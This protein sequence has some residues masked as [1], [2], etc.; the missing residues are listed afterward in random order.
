[1][2]VTAAAPYIP[3]ILLD[4]LRVGG[5]LVI[6]V[7]ESDTQIMTTIIKTSVISFDKKEHGAFRFVPM[8]CDR[9]KEK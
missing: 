9:A 5:I 7:G 3:D 2:I 6:P 4:Q 1:M 8:L